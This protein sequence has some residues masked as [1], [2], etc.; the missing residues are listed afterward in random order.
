MLILAF[1]L[2]SAAITFA[3]STPPI[4]QMRLVVDSPSSDAV[5]MNYVTHNEQRSYTNVL[6][7]QKTILLDQ[8][9]LQSAKPSVNGLGYPIV[10]ITFTDKGAKEFAEVTRQNIHKRLASIINNQV[11][12]APIIQMEIS[13]AKAQIDG[14]FSKQEVKDLA[15]EISAALTKNDT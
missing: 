14:S 8:T 10:E 1:C 7:V 13:G 5:P 11:C 15:K 12:E 4:F 3:A 9:A 2:L 6:Y